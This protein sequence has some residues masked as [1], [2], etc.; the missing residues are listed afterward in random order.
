MK[1]LVDLGGGVV[2]R[3]CLIELRGS[4]RARTGLTFPAVRLCIDEGPP[5]NQWSLSFR[6]RRLI[7]GRLDD[8]QVERLQ[9]Q[10][11][12][13]SYYGA[14]LIC[15]QLGEQL[16][17]FFWR[18]LNR[19]ELRDSLAELEVSDPELVEQSLS[20]L[21]QE[22]LLRLLRLLVQERFSLNRLPAL[23]EVLLEEHR[24]GRPLSPDRLVTPA[25]IEVMLES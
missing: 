10:E 6:R 8:L 5:S 14:G 2:L 12:C 16:P 13:V 1:K 18:F 24:L 15:A 11:L 3:N 17:Q 9:R 7:R 23:L 21:D 4:L 20:L 25:V 19:S 22:L